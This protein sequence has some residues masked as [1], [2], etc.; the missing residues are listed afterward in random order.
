MLK[1][2]MISPLLD[3]VYL[4]V[5]LLIQ[6]LLKYGKSGENYNIGAGVR[7]KNIKILK[8]ILHLISK[9]KDEKLKEYK[10]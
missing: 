3:I 6:R 4:L 9:M 5:S 1:I 8:D 7:R 2:N 10:N